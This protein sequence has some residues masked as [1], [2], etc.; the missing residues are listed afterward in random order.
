MK[1]DAE[2]RMQKNSNKTVLITGATS[3][4]G[5]EVTIRFAREG[6]D[7]L[8]HYFSSE[9]EAE[10]LKKKVAKMGIDCHLYNADFSSRKQILNLI[11][12]L[13]R[14]NITSLVN[15]AGSYTVSKNFSDLTIGDI[16]NTFM[17]N[18]FAPM[19]LSAH[20]FIQM[21]KNRFG[22]I[23]NISSIAAKYGGASHSMH[24]GCSKLALEGVTKT[25][26][27]EGACHNV[28]VNTIRPGVID[29]EFHKKFP[30]NMEKR[31]SLIP[32][33]KMGSPCDIADMAYY[34]GSE[35][36]NFIT[37]EILT[38]SGGE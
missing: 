3:G 32:L 6:W 30:K 31:I 7:I 21:K 33:K 25:L 9:N 15:N 27:R 13:K 5:R 20:I 23:V 1:K 29:T 4:I 24:Y 10:E 37:N 12:K 18:T 11:D 36:N 14:F 2:N 38:V 8:C 16:T 19:L 28:L 26:A 34:L 22:R 35:K 17:V